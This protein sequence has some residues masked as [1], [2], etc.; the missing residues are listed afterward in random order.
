MP[1]LASGAQE[2]PDSTPRLPVGRYRAWYA[3]EAPLRFSEFPG[4]AWRGGFGYALKNAACAT[5]EPR[6]EPCFLYRYCVYPYLF[7]TPPPPDAAKMRRYTSVPH[8]FVFDYR[9]QADAEGR[10][11]CCALEFSLFGAAN[12]HLPIV[13][14]ALR[15]AGA[16]EQGIAGNRL[17]LLRLEAE[18]QPGS[19]EW[20]ELELPGGLSRLVLPTAL[21]APALA[22]DVEL[23]IET[24]MRLKRE[25][26]HVG[27]EEFR[28]ADL[29]GNLLRRISML[30][31]FHTETPLETDFRGLSEAAK[32]VAAEVELEW[33]EQRR[34]SRRQGEAMRLGG[35]TGKVRLEAAGLA[36]FWPYLWLG[37]WT[38]A[39][40]GAT[41]GLGRYR[42][43]GL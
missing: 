24:P 11:D 12:R 14:Y 34:Y 28:F 40:S 42:I 38:H 30:T 9:P 41:M 37:Q 39:G 19:G 43:V 6:C 31:Y 3:A 8:P 10:E 21:E 22:G 7:E 23:V 15:E 4:S 2:E 13:V 18:S 20:R 17:R 35:V 32:S 29:F 26:R 25:G 36:P 33:R 16:T 1:G 5:K 27:P